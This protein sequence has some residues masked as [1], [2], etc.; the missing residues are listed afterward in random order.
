MLV[1]LGPDEGEREAAA[2]DGPVEL[3]EHERQRP[4]VILVAVRDEEAE[5]VVPAL[6]AAS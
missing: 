4:L 6:A 2:V 5:D 3:P 1:E